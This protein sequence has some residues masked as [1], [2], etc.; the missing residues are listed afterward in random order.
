MKQWSTHELH[1]LCTLFPRMIGEDFDAL[2]A[3]IY[4]N[5]LQSPIVLHDGMILDGGNRYRACQIANVEPRFVQFDGESVVA[6]VLSANLR[7]RHMSIGQQAAIVSSAQDWSKAQVQGAN[8]HTMKTGNDAGLHTVA[9]RAAQSGASDRTQRMADKVVRESPGD[10]AV[11]VAHGE[12]SLP[13]AAKELFAPDR[14]PK[15]AP[16]PDACL[17]EA[18]QIDE[19]SQEIAILR[20]EL[21]AASKDNAAMGEAFDADDKL[22]ILHRQNKELREV[23]RV[24][25]SRLDGEIN[26]NAELVRE[27]TKAQ[28]KIERMERASVQV[29]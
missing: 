23:N 29:P 2:V 17:S 6:F 24:L 22:T 19:M 7:R 20:R 11:R 9:D 27:V 3:D 5:G 1:P 26:K 18:D 12:M 10:L 13:A 21:D 14:K 8:R 25:Q 4:A 15:P 16:T 28:R